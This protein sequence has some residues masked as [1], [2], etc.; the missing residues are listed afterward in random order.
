[1]A[2]S[3]TNAATSPATGA[4]SSGMYSEV[5]WSGSTARSR[6]A[7]VDGGDRSSGRPRRWS[8]TTGVGGRVVDRQLDV[9]QHPLVVAVGHEQRAPLPGRRDREAVPV[10]QPDALLERVDAEAHPRQVEERQGR[11]HLDLDPALGRGSAS[12]RSTVRSSTRGEP[13]TA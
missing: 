8:T 12:S 4:A 13:G 7:H 9:G 1:M 3:S 11:Q 6:S 2:T 5:R 10:D